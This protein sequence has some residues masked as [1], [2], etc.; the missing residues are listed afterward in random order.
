M[1]IKR[2]IYASIL[3]S[4]LAPYLSAQEVR[5]AS[6][7]I[8]HLAEH[9]K[10]GCVPR[11][12]LDY[13][14]LRNFSELL[15]ADVIAL[16]EVENTAAVERVF[17][18]SE[19][20]IVLSDRPNSRSYNCRGNDQE[21]TQQR[22]AVVLRKGIKYQNKGS[23]EELGLKMEGLRYGVV[24]EIFGDRDT[25]NLLALHLKSGCFVDDYSTS[26]LRACEVLETQIET[27]DD[28]IENSIRENKKFIVLGD[29][30][31]RL[32]VENSMFWNK[33]VNM[34]NMPIGI[35]NGM[36]N[37]TGC[38]PRYPDLIDHIILGPETSKLQ[39]QNSQMVH[40]YSST[41]RQLAE[42]DMLSDH[43]PVS[44]VLRL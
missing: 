10:V 28:W 18:K 38:H 39:I 1:Y 21:S 8:E 32:T 2:T 44:L 26:K 27:L 17:P 24:V 19:W 41:G 40:F 5:V 22:V 35:Q 3:I 30:N 23:F 25:I 4:F 34:D 15:N 11:S 13:E 14:K 29:F 42:E 7:N 16:Q 31:S 33:L 20:N 12:T 36:Q 37:L 6:W 43:C 9:N